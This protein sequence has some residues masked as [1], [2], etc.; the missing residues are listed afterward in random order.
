MRKMKNLKK[1]IFGIGLGFS[2]MLGVAFSGVPQEVIAYNVDENEE[3]LFCFNECE[4]S[5]FYRHVD[6]GN[7]ARHVGK[8]IGAKASCQD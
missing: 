3:E 7:C 2:V 4:F 1:N 8:G 6:C 5:M